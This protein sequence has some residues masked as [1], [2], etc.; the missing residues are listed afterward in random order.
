M[1]KNDKIASELVALY[2]R[3]G[4]VRQPNSARF[5]EG[6]GYKKGWEIRWVAKDETEA[7]HI[8]KL[9]SVAGFKHGKTYLKN[10]LIVL[11]VYGYEAMEKFISFLSK[12]ENEVK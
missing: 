12:F 5:D 4:Y 9:L 8:S 1:K 3:N 11:P 6:Q 7:A 10:K 2:Q